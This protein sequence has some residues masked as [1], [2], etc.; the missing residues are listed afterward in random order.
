MRIY[1][2]VPLFIIL[3]ITSCSDDNDSENKDITKEIIDTELLP[4]EPIKE[5]DRNL[6]AKPIIKEIKKDFILSD[7]TNNIKQSIKIEDKKI[8]FE[9]IDKPIVILNFF[10]SWCSP[11]VGQ[12]PYLSDLQNK[13]KKYIS[14]IGLVVNEDISNND[15]KEFKKKNNVNFFLSNDQENN[16]Q[17]I[18]I[19]KEKL[20]I[21]K[22]RLPLAIMYQNDKYYIHYEG[23]VPIEMM[24]S[25]ILQILESKN[26]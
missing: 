12:T 26:N 17:I 1:L 7:S 2:L 21:D 20:K 13:Y 4:V 24:E 23:A 3:F 15:L 11:C 22:L 6:V 10:A 9:N 16:N 18:L 14:I 8:D 5:E 25:D 19:L